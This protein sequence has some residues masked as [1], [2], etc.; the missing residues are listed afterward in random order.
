MDSS[1]SHPP[2]TLRSISP[3]SAPESSLEHALEEAESAAIHWL[4][5]RVLDKTVFFGCDTREG[6]E[7]I[8]VLF[9]DFGHVQECLPAAQGPWRVIAARC[10]AFSVIRSEL[11]HMVSEQDGATARVR[12]WGGDYAHL[13]TALPGGGTAV[14]HEKPFTGISVACPESQTLYYLR[15]DDRPDVVHTEH[16][17][18][19]PLR[20]ALRAG[21][22]LPLHAAAC[23]IDDC[24]ILIAGDKGSGKSTL[25]MQLLQAGADFIAN[26]LCYLNTSPSNR[27][28]VTAFPKIIRLADGTIADIPFL[29]DWFSR[30][31]SSSTDYRHGAVFNA[32]K[33]EFYLHVL[34]HMIGQDRFRRHAPVGLVILPNF[35]RDAAEC[36]VIEM[37]YGGGQSAELN[38]VLADDGYPDW[39]CIDGLVSVGIQEREKL[40]RIRTAAPPVVKM[41]FG[42]TESDP[43]RV[44]ADYLKRFSR[45]S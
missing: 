19:Y 9:R 2:S 20:I 44:V 13:Q 8:E 21:P 34:Q 14:V 5:L 39:L 10:P 16:I 15:S 17:V 18:K 40:A 25:I 6:P 1:S 32:G 23:A 37:D 4:H 38:Q 35:H 43:A 27:L 42:P 30:Q 36:Q 45:P 28:T 33:H 22:Y 26:D 3:H 12:R 29:R 11:E 24:G 7:N 41:R 31:N